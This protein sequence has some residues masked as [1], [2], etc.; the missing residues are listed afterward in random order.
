[1]DPGESKSELVDGLV[2][3]LNNVFQT[4]LQAAEL[5]SC[6]ESQVELVDIIRRSVEQGQRILTSVEASQ[7]ASLLELIVDAAQFVADYV[8]VHGGATPVVVSRGDQNVHAAKPQGLERAFVNLFLNAAQ[9][10]QRNRSSRVVLTVDARLESGNVVLR[11]SDDGPGLPEA[12]RGRLFVAPTGELVEG[13][14]VGLQIVEA[15]IRNSGGSITA[16]NGE[17]GG[18]VFTILLPATLR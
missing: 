17:A 6:D 11:I 12:L 3:D 10:A 14:G 15:S 7:P 18:A 1:M 13:M 16:S 5:I 2:H 4:I 9:A 8:A